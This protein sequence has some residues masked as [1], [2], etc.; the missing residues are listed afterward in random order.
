MHLFSTPTECSQCGTMVEDPTAVDCPQ[1]GS[2]LRERRT[3]SR[4]A[5]VEKRYSNL[6]ILL[7]ALRFLGVTTILA[8]G[9]VFVFIA[10]DSL[11]P[12]TV[13][14]MI[15]FGALLLAVGLFA[16]AALFDVALDVEENTRASFRIQQKLLDH[17]HPEQEKERSARV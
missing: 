12:W 17:L 13:R 8:G 15:L 9:L 1:C 7:A 3:P 10:G 14:L 4:L 11:I 6:R 16:I 2:L 5:G